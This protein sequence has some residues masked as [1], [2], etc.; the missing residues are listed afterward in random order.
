[1]ASPFE[2]EFSTQEPPSEAQSHAAAALANA[3][4]GVGLKLS[5]QSEGELQYKPPIQF[6]ILLALSRRLGGEHMTVT[7]SPGTDGGTKVTIR[8]SIGR[9]RLQLASDPERWTEPLGGTATG[10]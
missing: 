3:A 1:M 4:K 9:N 6:P 10:S 5:N 2:V 8:G 7:F